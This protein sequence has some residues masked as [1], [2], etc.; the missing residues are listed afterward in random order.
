MVVA[1][2]I[3]DL[4]FR[5]LL[6]EGAKL[7]PEAIRRIREEN[8]AFILVQEPGTEA[9]RADDLIGVNVRR[10]VAGALETFS[11]WQRRDL[12]SA[13][14]LS[15]VLKGGKSDGMSPA[16][17]QQLI[18]DAISSLIK[19]LMFQR[20]PVYYPGIYPARNRLINHSIN[21]AI[22]ALLVGWK[23]RMSQQELLWLG[24]AALLHDVGK[25]RLDPN[26]LKVH[27]TDY[28]EEQR[29]AYSMH[30]QMSTVL[31]DQDVNLNTH[32]TMGVM[33]HHE[34][35]D[36]SGFPEKLKGSNLPPASKL[37][38]RGSIHRFAE[39]IAVSNYFDNLVSGRVKQEQLTPPE[40]VKEI[41]GTTPTWFNEHIVNEALEV[42]NV[43][44]VGS[45]VRLADSSRGAMI[46]YKG[47]VAK[48]NL[49]DQHRPVITL[50]H[51]QRQRLD[52]PTTIDLADDRRA[53]LEYINEF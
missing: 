3:Y 2:P 35:Q 43:F 15:K 40:A 12:E 28:S 17:I 38:P 8:F 53:R 24:K 36:G 13:E 30:P 49:N 20:K 34:K 37:R 26:L 32:I 52:Q 19:E 5:K 33:Q 22:L 31:L 4:Q 25:M 16:D 6:G 9:I 46:G 18:E 21:V 45:L 51:S 42:I 11:A 7:Q 48:M 1:R 14:E 29:I 23:F 44:P 47:V 39:I 41:I 50:L 10:E 27:P